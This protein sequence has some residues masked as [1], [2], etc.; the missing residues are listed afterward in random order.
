MQPKPAQLDDVQGE[1]Y[2]EIVTDGNGRRR[3]SG[4]FYSDS[5]SDGFR[6]MPGNRDYSTF[7]GVVYDRGQEHQLSFQVIV[8]N[9]SMGSSHGP[10]AHFTASGNPFG[11]N[12]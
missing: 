6:M 5:Q 8:T 4:V 11:S 9:V 1:G 7:T 2:A 10:V 3:C 12:S